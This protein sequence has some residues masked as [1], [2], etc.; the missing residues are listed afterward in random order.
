MESKKKR[1]R[2]RLE[3]DLEEIEELAEEGNTAEDIAAALGIGRTTLYKRKDAKAAF[4]KGRASL[5]VNL[6]HWQIQTARSGNVSMLIWLGKQLLGQ[7]EQPVLK[8]DEKKRDDSLSAS[9]REMADEI[10]KARGVPKK[11]GIA[12]DK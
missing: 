10:D 6:R 8:K 1:G 3:L 4:D 7:S 9:L 2:P 11:G 5:R 12:D